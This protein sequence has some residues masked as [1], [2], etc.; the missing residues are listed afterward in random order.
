[1]VRSLQW[2]VS[3]IPV[4]PALHTSKSL[5]DALGLRQHHSAFLEIMFDWLMCVTGAGSGGGAGQE[6]M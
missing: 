4:V 2:S 6:G 5:A 3:F 1:M